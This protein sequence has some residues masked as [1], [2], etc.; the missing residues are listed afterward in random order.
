MIE[1]KVKDR[2]YNDNIGSTYRIRLWKYKY[3]LRH[4]ENVGIKN[5]KLNIIRTIVMNNKPLMQN[6]CCPF[7]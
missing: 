4:G 6:M 1:T 2:R 3:C 7:L 5:T